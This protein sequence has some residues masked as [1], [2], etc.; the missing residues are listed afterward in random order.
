MKEGEPHSCPRFLPAAVVCGGV[1]GK[2]QREPGKTMEGQF[3]EQSAR[4][5]RAAHRGE[6]AVC[7]DQEG[8][9]CIS[10]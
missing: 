8:L 6:A 9:P 10:K 7:P 2:T 4:K 3:I 5:E 1:A